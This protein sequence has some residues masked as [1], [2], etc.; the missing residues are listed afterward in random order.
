MPSQGILGEIPAD[1][2]RKGISVST[3]LR[4]E[5]LFSVSHEAMVYRLRALSVISE[6]DIERL[7]GLTISDVA[8]ANGYDLSLYQKGNENVTLGD[9]GS[10]ARKL[11]E[12]EKISEGHYLELL[13]QIT[14]EKQ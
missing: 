6:S 11:Y 4:L 7:F 1:E 3:I 8:R 13:N 9:F 14:D 2:L 10:N 12:M 5:Q